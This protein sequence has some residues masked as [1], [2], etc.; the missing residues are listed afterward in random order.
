MI[1]EFLTYITAT[2][3][4]GA[5]EIG[6]VREVA[7]ITGRYQ[8]NQQKW[9]P[10]LNATKS[11]IQEA[12]QN[13][14]DQKPIIILGAGLLLDIPLDA[15]NKHPAGA[16]LIDAVLPLSTRIKLLHYKNIA[17][18]TQDITG[19]IEPWLL[20]KN[21]NPV[22]R[23]NPRLPKNNYGLI[24]SVNLL[25]QLPLAF[26]P[27][28]T[29]DLKLRDQIQIDHI[30]LLNR[31]ADHAVIISDYQHIETRPESTQVSDSISKHLQQNMLGIPFKK[32]DWHIAPKGEIDRDVSLSMKIGCWRLSDQPI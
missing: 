22:P 20:A 13:A 24:I 8:R 7:A 16:I 21:N 18:H 5:R 19:L 26:L 3:A 12:V 23:G 27:S 31:H 14:P 25:S 15:L 6:I 10:H 4:R 29:I 17:F 1:R 32:W 11:V 30:D 2:S 28:N 9:L